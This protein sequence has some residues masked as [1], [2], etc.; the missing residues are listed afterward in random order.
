MQDKNEQNLDSAN[1]GNTQEMDI[2]INLDS[3]PVLYTDNIFITASSEGIVLDFS[4]KLVLTNKIRIVARIGMSK[5]HAKK[6]SEQLE[7]MLKVAEGQ[8]QSAEKKIKN[9]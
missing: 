7:A 4:Q 5:D 1:K 6:F 3:T 2:N 9:N 8:S